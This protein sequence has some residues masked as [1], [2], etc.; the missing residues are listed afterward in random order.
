MRLLLLLLSS[1]LVGCA[2]HGSVMKIDGIYHHI[3]TDR[4]ASCQR[5]GGCYLLVDGEHRIYYSAA[6]PGY[7]LP[8][9]L[10]HAKGM[11]HTEWSRD[12]WAG[13]VCAV[14]SVPAQGYPLGAKICIDGRHE[15]IITRSDHG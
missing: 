9:E 11:R 13:E 6:S 2:D 5:T 7:V 1:L 15:R 8:H 3:D 10:G 12:D 4:P 14:V